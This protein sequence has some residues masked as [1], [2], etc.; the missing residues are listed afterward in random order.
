MFN[1]HKNIEF[2]QEIEKNG[3]INF[4]DLTI[5]RQNCGLKFRI[6]RKP[7][8]TDQT[9]H[10]DL[11]H[12]YSHKVAAYHSFIHRLLSIPMSIDDFKEEVNTV[13]LNT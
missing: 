11:H 8:C 12:P 7:T 9:I 1:I 5:T 10:Y 3:A 13:P 6:Y 4:L 2:T